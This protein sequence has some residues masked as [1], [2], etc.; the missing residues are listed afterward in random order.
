[1]SETEMDLQRIRQTTLNEMTF[2]IRSSRVIVFGVM[3]I[4]I[5]IQIIVP[6]ET[7]SERM[8]S[9]VSCFEAFLALTNSGLILLIIPVLYL[10]IMAEFPV[11]GSAEYFFQMRSKKRLWV[12]GQLFFAFISAVCTVC[13]LMIT[14]VGMSLPF[15]NIS[16]E[17]SYAATHYVSF[18]PENSND[19]IS[20][21]IPLNLFQQLTFTEAMV[22]TFLLLSL[23]LFMISLIILF[24]S[25]MNRK[26]IGLIADAV[27]IILGTITCSG[28]FSTKWLFPMA[29]SIS[30]YHYE[31]YLSQPVMD[32]KISYIY[33]LAID[34]GLI[35]LCMMLA[36]KFEPGRDNE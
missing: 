5:H 8:N 19:Y 27:M 28:N 34:F 24:A 21:L 11:R 6:L 12:I 13:I 29:H 20:S 3:I 17:Y 1:M 32:L 9:P 16:W 15:G 2:W 25:V 33:F 7:L 31:E 30:W 26:L 10:V 36:N 18:Y 35:L 22:H 4:F 23:N 14:A